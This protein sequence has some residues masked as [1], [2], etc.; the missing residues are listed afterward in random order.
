MLVQNRA[1]MSCVGF[2]G[3]YFAIEVEA[4]VNLSVVVLTFC[5][6]YGGFYISAY[7]CAF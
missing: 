3:T 2:D 1:R 4:K 6:M 7:V 5:M